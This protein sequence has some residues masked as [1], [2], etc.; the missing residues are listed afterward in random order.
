MYDYSVLQ[1]VK[2]SLYYYNEDQIA[3]DIQHY[4]SAVTHELNSTAT[5]IFTGESLH[6]TDAF[7][8]SIENRFHV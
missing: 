1:Q 6:V 3:K 4:I 7:L 8:E 5:C 2:E